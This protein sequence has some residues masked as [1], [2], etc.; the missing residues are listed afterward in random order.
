MALAALDLG[1]KKDL[2]AG[3]H[4]LRINQ[5]MDLAIQRDDG[6]LLQMPAQTRVERVHR[7][8][9]AAHGGGRDI[10]FRHPIRVA[11]AEA[12]GE[13]DPR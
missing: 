10:E 6:F 9:D 12:A 5:L 1:N 7:L 2:A 8:D 11:A 3:R 13:D 4:R